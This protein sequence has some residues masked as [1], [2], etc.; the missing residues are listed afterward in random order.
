MSD[1]KDPQILLNRIR[2]PD[3]V[4]LTSRYRHD[5]V[6]HVDENG[7][8]YAVDGGFDYLRRVGPDDYEELSIDS[9]DD[10]KVIRKNFERGVSRDNI[11]TWKPLDSLS[12]QHLDNIISYIDEYENNNNP[13]KWVYE[14]EILYREKNKINIKEEVDVIT[15]DD[16]FDL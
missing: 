16:I 11:I 9:N 5:Y 3:G 12:N 13:F 7:N 6:S 15:I 14:K 4:I 2:T 1:K 8:L 10:W